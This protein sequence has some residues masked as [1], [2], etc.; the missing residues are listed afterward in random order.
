[1]TVEARSLSIILHSPS[2][3]T[4]LSPALSHKLGAGSSRVAYRETTARSPSETAI[5]KSERYVAP[6]SWVIQQTSAIVACMA[7]A[8]AAASRRW[9]R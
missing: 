4:Y 9:P 7:S 6:T 1:M 3:H 8:I 2:W 5:F